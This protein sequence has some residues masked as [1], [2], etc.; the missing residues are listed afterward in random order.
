MMLEVELIPCCNGRGPTYLRQADETCDMSAGAKVVVLVGHARPE[1]AVAA[2]HM[3]PRPHFQQQ[4]GQH[5]A[6]RS[7]RDTCVPQIQT[8][9]KDCQAFDSAEKVWSAF[10]GPLGPACL[11][12]LGLTKAHGND[13]GEASLWHLT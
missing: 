3:V 6:A 12:M 1:N 8:I 10:D 9:N 7:R 11:L 5:R 4:L 2:C 13:Y